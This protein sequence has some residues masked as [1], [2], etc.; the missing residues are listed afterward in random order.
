MDVTTLTAGRELDAEIGRVFPSLVSSWRVHAVHV[1]GKAI[2]AQLIGREKYRTYEECLAACKPSDGEW[3]AQTPVPSEYFST[4][5]A[6]AWEV[7]EVVDCFSLNIERCEV[8]S[9]HFCDGSPEGICG[10][11]ETL[12]LAICKAALK[13]VQ[14]G[15]AD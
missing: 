14:R 8:W 7:V 1:N 3:S 15:A 13:C 4:D 9:V 11:A 10:T 2:S 6:A 5:I 12:P